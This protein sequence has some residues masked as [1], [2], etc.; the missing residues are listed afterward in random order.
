MGYGDHT[1][2]KIWSDEITEHVRIN[3][4]TPNHIPA[5]VQPYTHSVPSS[6]GAV[7]HGVVLLR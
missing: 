3:L 5:I 6:S 2:M 4:A 1:S 7:D